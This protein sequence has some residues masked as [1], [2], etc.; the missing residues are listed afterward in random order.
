MNAIMNLINI[1]AIST[2]L[3]FAGCLPWSTVGTTTVCKGSISN[4]N[5]AETLD[6]QGELWIDPITWGILTYN[7]DSRITHRTSKLK[8]M[9]IFGAQVLPLNSPVRFTLDYHDGGIATI[10][11][12]EYI[13]SLGLWRVEVLGIDDTLHTVLLLDSIQYMNKVLQNR[14]LSD[15]FILIRTPCHFAASVEHCLVEML[16]SAITSRIGKSYSITITDDALQ[17]V[18]ADARVMTLKIVTEALPNHLIV[19]VNNHS[20]SDNKNMQGRGNLF[21]IEMHDR[22]SIFKPALGDEDEMDFQVDSK[23]AFELTSNTE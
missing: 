13:D 11:Q 17:L 2:W 21:A 8:A 23:T 19:R 15:E 6:Y 3:T 14:R 1:V 7:Y 16:S 4:S 12:T 18:K 20:K 9:W 10:S 5:V 22:K